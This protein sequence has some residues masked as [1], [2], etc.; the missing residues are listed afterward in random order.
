MF[1]VTIN[2]P[3]AF[4]LRILL[5]KLKGSDLDLSGATDPSLR[6]RSFTFAA[7]RCV[8]RQNGQP[9]LLE[10]YQEAC[11]ARGLTTDD[12]EWKEALEEQANVQTSGLLIREAFVSILANN[13]VGKPQALFDAF[14]DKMGDDLAVKFS[15][16]KT[17]PRYASAYIGRV[18]LDVKDRLSQVGH[19]IEKY[20]ISVSVKSISDSH[21]MCKFRTVDPVERLVQDETAED[22]AQQ[23]A[24]ASKTLRVANTMQRAFLEAVTRRLD[25]KKPGLFFVDA[26]GGTGPSTS[27]PRSTKRRQTLYTNLCEQPTA[28]HKK[29]FFKRCPAAGQPSPSPVSRWLR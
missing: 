23:A 24:L 15:K 28:N 10:S 14:S 1:N 27:P 21:Y 29:Q 22:L 5:T 8:T 11:C 3:E 2:K 9:E 25:A 18:F 17:D 26:P 20:A 4:Y 13:C 12:S 19:D 16:P 6:A 7:L